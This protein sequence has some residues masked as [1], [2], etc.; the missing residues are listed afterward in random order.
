[1]IDNETISNLAVKYQTDPINVWREYFQHLFL[2]YFYKQ[3]DTDK[4]YFKGGTAL[5]IIY[6]S[7]RFSEDLDFS[8]SIKNISKI[9]QAIINTLTEIE[10]GGIVTK[11]DEAKLTTGGYLT[12]IRFRNNGQMIVIK[13]EISFR[14]GKKK[15]ELATIASDFIPPYTIMQLSQRFIVQGK[16]DALLDRRKPRDFYDLYYL[17][18]ANLIDTKRKEILKDA[19]SALKEAD[20]N[21]NQELKQFLPKSHWPI[22]RDFPATLEREIKRFLG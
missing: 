16:I 22:I 15:G 17:L 21:F 5:R 13:L 1:M 12:L 6:Q 11:L 4:I 9:E 14:A 2:S 19:L 10:R 20:I 18:R 8:S 7:P 3:S